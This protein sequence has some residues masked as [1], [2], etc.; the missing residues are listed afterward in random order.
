VRI[1][2]KIFGRLR[3]AEAPPP[4][5]PTQRLYARI[6]GSS[7][8]SPS[9]WLWEEVTPIANGGWSTAES[10]RTGVAREA[11]GNDLRGL[12]MVTILYKFSDSD[13]FIFFAGS[14]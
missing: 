14:E 1:L 11:N 2:D 5:T 12:P 10:G 6:T 4:V 13:A 9:D 7:P 8:D 3:Q